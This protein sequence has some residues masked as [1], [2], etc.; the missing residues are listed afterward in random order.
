MLSKASKSDEKALEALN[1][2]KAAGFDSIE[3]NSFM[4]HPSS[5][6]VR[7]IAKMLYAP[8]VPLFSVTHLS[9]I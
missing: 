2:V 1:R 3:L 6:M 4:V 7:G 9:C 8:T 5:I